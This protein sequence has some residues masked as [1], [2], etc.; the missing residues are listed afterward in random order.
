[1][2]KKQGRQKQPSLSEAKPQE[3][4]A[5]SAGASGSVSIIKKPDDEEELKAPEFQNTLGMALQAAFEQ[6]GADKRENKR[7]KKGKQKKKAEFSLEL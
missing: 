7:G 5:F 6:R 4:S 3:L 2:L 1:M